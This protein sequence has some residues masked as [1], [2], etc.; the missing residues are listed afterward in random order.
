M[1]PM[2]N[3]AVRAARAAGNVIT[4]HMDRLDTLQVEAKGRNDLVSEV[5][6][7]AEQEIVAVLRKA[8][9]HH[10]ILGEEGGASGNNEFEWVIDPLDGTTNFLHG[11]PH[12]AVSIGLRHNGRV[13][14]GVI[15]DP[16]RQELY[17]ANRGGGAQLDGRRIRVSRRA[18]VD[19]AL[20]GTGFPFRVSQ[21]FDAYLRMFHAFTG[22]V[23]DMRRAGSAALDLAYV[24]AGRLDG[25]WE[26]GLGPWD[27]AAGLLMV[28]EAGG[29]VGDFMGGARHFETGNIVA[30]NPKVFAGMLRE[31]RP[32]VTPELGR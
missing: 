17:T 29:L 18:E 2:V 28:Q 12:F 23:A 3:I 15:Y 6:R 25:Y 1:H 31:I 13:E 27:M 7:L 30:A 8:Y 11:I 26:I 19:D 32:F 14:V 22:K 21:H 10:A 20:I 16:V 4:R 9:P 24:A 5:D